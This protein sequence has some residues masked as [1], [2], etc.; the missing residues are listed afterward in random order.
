MK[1]CTN[2]LSGHAHRAEALLKILNVPYDAIFE[3][4]CGTRIN[5][6][7]AYDTAVS[8]AHMLL[9]TLFEP[10]LAAND[11]LRAGGSTI[12]DISNTGYIAA[13]PEAGVDLTAY[14]NEVSWLRRY[15]PLTTFPRCQ[16]SPT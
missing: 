7:V 1:L 11:W 3:G 6:P 9:E 4:P 2:P 5:K 14:P 13:A 8:K 10:H 16:T 15:E 12:A